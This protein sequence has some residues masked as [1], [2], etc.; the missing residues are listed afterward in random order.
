[1]YILSKLS[2]NT[3]NLC[4]MIGVTNMVVASYLL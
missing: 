3:N 4:A 2:R 1:M